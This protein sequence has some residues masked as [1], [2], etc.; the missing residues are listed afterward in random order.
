MRGQVRVAFEIF[1]LDPGLHRCVSSI[2]AWDAAHV[3][4][5]RILVG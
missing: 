3:L 2:I 5:S 1:V 4:H